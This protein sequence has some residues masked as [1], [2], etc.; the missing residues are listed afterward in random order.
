MIDSDE[1]TRHF[2]LQVKAEKYSMVAE[3]LL[4]GI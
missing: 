1:F 3:R 4:H 2:I